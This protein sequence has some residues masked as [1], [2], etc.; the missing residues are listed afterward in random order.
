M[1]EQL[2]SR[3]VERAET[4]QRMTVL[5]TPALLSLSIDFYG[6]LASELFKQTNRSLQF[7]QIARRITWFS[8]QQIRYNQSRIARSAA[9]ASSHSIDLQ[10]SLT[11]IPARE[12]LS[13]R[14]S[15]G[16]CDELV[17]LPNWVDPLKFMNS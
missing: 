12:N 15:V 2:A 13:D 16:F 11:I 6:C 8:R 1:V 5:V 17:E 10:W 9:R 4:T 14:F 7:E 3:L